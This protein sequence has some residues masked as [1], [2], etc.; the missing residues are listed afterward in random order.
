MF[1]AAAILS[2]MLSSQADRNLLL[3]W[4]ATSNFKQRDAR[5]NF[6]FRTRICGAV[7]CG[8]LP[9][10]GHE[11]IGVDTNSLKVGMINDGQSPV[12]EDGINELITRAVKEGKLR[13]THDVED[14]VLNSDISLISVATPSQITRRT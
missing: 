2:G 13:A 9:E 3:A 5:E 11:V 6:C 7:S 10:L 1:C 8:C 14:A 4:P 12:V